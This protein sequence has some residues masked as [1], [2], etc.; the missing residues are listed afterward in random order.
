MSTRIPPVKWAE[1]NDRVFVTIDVAGVK[2]GEAQ[3][4]LE[5]SG[6][7]SFHCGQW[8]LDAELLKEVDHAKSKWGFGGRGVLFDIVK[9]EE[10]YWNRLFKVPA[11]K[12]SWLSV[13][14]SRWKDEDESDDEALA[15]PMAGMDFSSL[16]GGANGMDFGEP[17][18]ADDMPDLEG[19]DD[20]PPLEEEGDDDEEKK[21]K[22]EG[23][24][25]Q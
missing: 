1:R 5:D 25:K 22:G 7:F 15:D 21:K 12:P 14:W 13:D 23:E 8:A 3:V 24:D 17:M 4:V 10:G 11:G 18:G 2:P 9:K 6:K 20:M 16:M 19:D